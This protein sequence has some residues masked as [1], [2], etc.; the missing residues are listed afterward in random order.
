MRPRSALLL[1]LGLVLLVLLVPRPPTSVPATT[2]QVRDARGPLAGALVRVKG[3]PDS[4]TS[5]ADGRFQLPPA[6]HRGRVTAWKDGYFIAG[7]PLDAA[8]LNLQLH[9]LPQQ[10]NP[11]YRWVDPAP[12]P[13]G[14]HNCANCHQEIYREWDES[15]HAHAA[16]G[17]HFRDLY[18]GTVGGW[19]LLRQHPDGAGVCAACHAPTVSAGDPAL[20][21]LSKVQGVAARGVHCD[22]CHKIT[23]LTGDTLGLA[24]GRDILTLLRPAEGQLFLGPL[25]DVDRGEDAYSAFYRDSR[26]CAACHEGVVFGVH[27]YSTYSEW[28]DSPARAQ[29]RHCQDCHMK[30]TDRMTNIAPGKGGIQRDPKKLGNHRFFDGSREQMLRRCLRLDGSMV[31]EAGGVRF[32]LK[33]RPEGVGHRVPTGFVDRHLV[34]SVEGLDP[35]GQRVEP[36]AGP[37]LPAVAGAELEGRPGRVFAKLL[38]DDQGHSPAPFW[39][40]DLDPED[41][42]LK[43]GR[44]EQVEYRFPASVHTFRVRLIHRRFWQE[45]ARAK[46]W[47]DS[48]LVLIDRTFPQ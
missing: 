31:P 13:Q 7:S 47:P 6:P 3:Y 45:V 42:R 15:A 25:D 36:V 24:H 16:T 23:G 32:T 22:H 11:T 26:Y 39:K 20:F 4:T 44:A 19:G 2:G 21:D 12:D 35:E 37:R 41:T 34:L 46:G 28:L 30:P 48:D 9:P 38:K 29:G 27:V 10:D 5:D 8:P 33:L 1:I 18:L 17:R 14:Q 40:A 43:P